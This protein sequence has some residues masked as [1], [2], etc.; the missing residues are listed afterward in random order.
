M[1]ELYELEKPDKPVCDLMGNELIRGQV[2]AYSK[3][4]QS[5]RSLYVGVITT[6]LKMGGGRFSHSIYTVSAGGWLGGEHRANIGV[7]D[8]I[9]ILNDP[10]FSLN[11]KRIAKLFEMIDRV[12]GKTHGDIF[13]IPNPYNPNAVWE[14]EVTWK[15]ILPVDYQYGEPIDD[16]QMVS[17]Q[18]KKAVD[19]ANRQLKKKR[20][21][22]K[23]NGKKV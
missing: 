2:I 22:E 20:K 18:N 15:S 11:S 1:S 23:E 7:N 8:S 13:Q 21:A 16:T 3:S 5:G 9:V 17:I 12:R 10:L 6:I 4:G 14:R 19:R